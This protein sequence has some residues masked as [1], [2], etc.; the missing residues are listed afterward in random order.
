MPIL[1]NQR[2]LRDFVMKGVNIRGHRQGGHVGISSVDDGAGLL[3][4]SGMGG[5]DMDVLTGFCLPILGEGIVDPGV[6]FAGR[7]VAHI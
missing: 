1:G 2:L 5:R 6:E 7:V 4:G 3:A